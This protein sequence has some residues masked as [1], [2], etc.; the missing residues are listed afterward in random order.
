MF[1]LVKIINNQQST[2]QLKDALHQLKHENFSL[3]YN[4]WQKVKVS[5]STSTISKKVPLVAS[6]EDFIK[7]LFLEIEVSFILFVCSTERFI[8]FVLIE[9]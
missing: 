4:E 1:F 3:T 6:I 2:K 5:G 9:S 7:Q 8:F